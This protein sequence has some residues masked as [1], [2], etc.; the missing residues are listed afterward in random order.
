MKNDF[1][2]LAGQ[3]GYFPGLWTAKNFFLPRLEIISS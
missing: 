2:S 1:W 3:A